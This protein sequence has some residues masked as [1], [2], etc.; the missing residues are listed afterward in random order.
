MQ[1]LQVKHSSVIAVPPF[2]YPTPIL[3]FCM[4][5]QRVNTVTKSP[6]LID[7]AYISLSIS[8]KW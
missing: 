6:T 3:W 7:N 5:V 1:V 2:L 4:Y 8:I